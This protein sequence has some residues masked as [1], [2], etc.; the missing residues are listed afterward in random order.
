MSNTLHDLALLR[1]SDFDLS[2]P[3]SSRA[4]PAESRSSDQ[5]EVDASVELSYAFTEEARKALKVLNTAAV[6]AQGSK[7]DQSRAELEEALQAM[8]S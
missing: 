1:V 3:L 5:P 8:E 6:D 2:T 4:L 7:V